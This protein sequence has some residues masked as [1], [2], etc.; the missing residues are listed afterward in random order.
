MKNNQQSETGNTCVA[1][2]RSVNYGTG[3]GQQDSIS[4]PAL[5]HCLSPTVIGL[6]GGSDLV[7]TIMADNSKS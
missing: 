7:A 5:Q 2:P 1:T 4:Q 6:R 3:R